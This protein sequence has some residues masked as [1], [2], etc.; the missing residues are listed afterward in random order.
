MLVTRASLTTVY[1]SCS[2]FTPFVRPTRSLRYLIA[3]RK[4]RTLDAFLVALRHKCLPRVMAE[5]S[6]AGPSSTSISATDSMQSLELE[7][8]IVELEEAQ[9]VQEA[10]KE[11]SQGESKEAQ[12]APEKPLPI[13]YQLYSWKTKAPHTRLVYI[14]D[15][16]D[17]ER[18]LSKFEPGPLGFDL[19]WKPNR[20]RGS[21]NPVALVQLASHDTILLI[22]VTAMRSFPS[23]LKTLLAD[24]A[25]LKAG[26][27]IQN[28][29]KKLW[30]DYRVSTRNCVDLALLARTVDNARW[31]GKYTQPIGLARLCQVYENLDLS[32]GKITR[33]NWELYLDELQQEYAA[34]DCH[35]GL[36]LYLRLHGMMST[37]DSTPSRAYYS[38]D[39]HEGFLYHPSEGVPRTLWRPHN[40]NYDPGPPPE[41]KERKEGDAS[42]NDSK[43][44]ADSTPPEASSSGRSRR[45]NPSRQY[46][47]PA[48][49]AAGASGITHPMTSTGL[50]M[51][52]RHSTAPR[53]QYPQ[54]EQVQ[55]FTV[56]TRT[57]RI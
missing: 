52:T 47:Q 29:C 17:A 20:W 33:S 32:K 54:M 39:F 1:H 31:K 14:R 28:D 48:L 55:N 49:L 35:S 19:E 25:Y 36:T 45:H 40:P 42:A 9:E 11:E 5:P 44:S 27:G 22:Q 43:E 37:L 3:P 7:V 51:G 41:R 23:K 24:P 18:E 57:R 30:E 21:N 6:H 8:Q 10:A 13:V 53:S 46:Y 26:V 34:N 2:C 38:F 56:P 16:V 12:Q 15:T 50:M 4:R